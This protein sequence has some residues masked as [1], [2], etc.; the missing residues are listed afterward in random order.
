M[1][2]KTILSCTSVIYDFRWTSQP[3]HDQITVC[4]GDSIVE[5]GPQMY[6]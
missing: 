6:P 3:N 2:I 4:S 5:E 1:N